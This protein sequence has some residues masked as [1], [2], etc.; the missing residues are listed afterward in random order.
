MHNQR[1]T[2]LKTNMLERKT[3]TAIIHN[4]ARDTIDAAQE[5]RT[6]PTPLP[7]SRKPPDL[8]A[9]SPSDERH[10]PEKPRSATIIALE[11]FPETLKYKPRV[12]DVMTHHFQTC[13]CNEDE[14]SIQKDAN[15]FRVCEDLF[16]G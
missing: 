13:S 11:N 3:Q 12:S 6:A 16:V 10:Q 9:I 1:A 2:V 8:P 14:K 15:R 7:T 4:K 5:R